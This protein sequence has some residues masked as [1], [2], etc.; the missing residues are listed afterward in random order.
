[1][2]TICETDRKLS[3]E[4]KVLQVILRHDKKIMLTRKNT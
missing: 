3:A 4:G 2:G 1:M